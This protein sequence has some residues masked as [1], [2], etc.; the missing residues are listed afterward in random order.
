MDA[1]IAAASFHWMARQR[2]CQ[3][4]ARWLRAGGLFYAFCLGLTEVATPAAAQRAFEREH[5]QWHA[6]QDQRLRHWRPY[7][8]DFRASGAFSSVQDVGCA[9]LYEWPADRVA[10]FFLSTSDGYEFARRT[11]AIA[12]YETAL[13]RKL[14]EAG[15]SSA[16]AFPMKGQ[17]GIC[18][19]VL[20][21]I[22]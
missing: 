8:E 22:K 15:A 17:L 21:A 20:R 3:Q 5:E 12:A 9:V 2:V 18:N 4:A 11:G 14:S 1:V 10:G 19:L 16:C 13:I 7:G 6:V